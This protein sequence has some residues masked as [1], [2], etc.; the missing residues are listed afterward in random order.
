MRVLPLVLISLLPAIAIA[1]EAKAP[2]PKPAGPKDSKAAAPVPPPAP[3]K[4]P[5]EVGMTV[6]NFKGNWTFDASLTAPG[7]AKPATFKMTFNC[8][9]IALGTGVSCDAKA[10]TPMGPYE[11]TFLIAY[12]PFSKAVHFIAVTSGY[13]VH[14][15][16]CQWDQGMAG[17][18]GLGCT[19][20]KG[21]SGPDGQAITEDLLIAFHKEGKEAE[22]TSTSHLKAGGDILFTGLGKRK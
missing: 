19:P 14:D 21:G 17:K 20:F 3:A 9:P 6:A 15:H 18:F 11:G 10:K 4:P 22:F 1:D 8:K 16:V 2:V 12:D 5:A 13:E 7:M